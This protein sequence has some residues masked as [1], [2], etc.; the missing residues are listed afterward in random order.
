MIG[1]RNGKTTAPSRSM[2]IKTKLWIDTAAD[3]NCEKLIIL[4]RTK[5]EDPLITLPNVCFDENSG[6]CKK[7]ENEVRNSH[8]HDEVVD[9]SSHCCR[10]ERMFPISAATMRTLY[11]NVL[12][13]VSAT[14]LPA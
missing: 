3:T 13:T 7:W 6:K 11:A 9:C 10:R 1:G 5:P 8:V 14:A 12:A 4:H 2:A